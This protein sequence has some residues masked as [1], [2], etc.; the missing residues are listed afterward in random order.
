MLDTRTISTEF[1][2]KYLENCISIFMDFVIYK[3]IENSDVKSFIST[4]KKTLARSTNSHKKFVNIYISESEAARMTSF[5]LEIHKYCDMN[6]NESFVK[7]LKLEP[8]FF[9]D[10]FTKISRTWAGR[11]PNISDY[12]RILNNNDRLDPSQVF[13]M[14][15]KTDYY[16]QLVKKY[17]DKNRT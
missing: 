9:A 15:K 3:K 6:P 10:F 5:P 7:E 12:E 14:K 16:Y 11:A 2:R 4:V 17:N 8:T 13:K 1:D